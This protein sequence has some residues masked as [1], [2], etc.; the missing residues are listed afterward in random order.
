MNSFLVKYVLSISVHF[1][2]NPFIVKECSIKFPNKGLFTFSN[3]HGLTFQ[4][5]LDSSSRFPGNDLY[6]HFG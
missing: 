1:H 6:P 4:P 2:D 5:S 3:L